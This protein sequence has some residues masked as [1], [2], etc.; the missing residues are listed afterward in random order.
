MPPDDFNRKH[1]Q[2]GYNQHYS[3]GKSID[4]ELK[5]LDKKIDK[6]EGNDKKDS[7]KNIE[8]EINKVEKNINEMEKDPTLKTKKYSDKSQIMA[9][10]LSVIFGGFAAGRFYVGYYELAIV[11]LILSI[12]FFC[13]FCTCI[14]CLCRWW[15]ITTEVDR[16]FKPYHYWCCFGWILISIAYITWWLADGIMFARN[17]IED[18]SNGLPLKPWKCIWGY[19]CM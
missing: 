7:G 10:S 19:D 4:N 9:Y 2:H 8:K 12:I 1:N 17:E 14:C 5:E 13:G 15:A 6:F 18:P 16:E 11:K 3:A